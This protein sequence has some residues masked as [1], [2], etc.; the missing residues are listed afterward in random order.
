MDLTLPPLPRFRLYSRASDYARIILE[1]VAGTSDHGPG[2][3]ELESQIA[4]FTGASAATCVAKARVGVFLAMREILKGRSKTVILSPYTISDVVNMVI[5]AGGVPVFADLDKGTCN[6]SLECIRDLLCDDIGAVLITHLHGFACDVVGIGDLCRSHGVPVIEDAA[7]ALGTRVNNQPVGTFG[8]AGVFSFGAYKNLN[9]FFGGML[10]SNDE[11]LIE[12]V[13]RQSANFPEQ[14]LGYYLR[15]VTEC[16][17]TDIATHPLV[18][19]A[20]TFW[21]FRLA[22]LYDIG[23]FNAQVSYDLEPTLKRI[24]PETYLRRMRPLQARLGLAKLPQVDDD[25]EVRTQKA[26]MYFEGLKGAPGIELPPNRTDRSHTYTYFPIRV[27]DRRKYIR[28][29]MRAGRDV[30]IQH[31]KNCADLDCFAEFHRDCP[32]AR[33]TSREVVLLPTYPRYSV[34]EVERTI[35]ATRRYANTS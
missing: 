34:Q 31:L 24:L 19:R 14:E 35:S 17:A 10:V 21:I 1:S 20:F 27:R 13:S 28:H 22:T 4:Q 33:K 23:A 15:K 30:G 18:F 3:Q 16:L 25:A 5:C 29:M 11:T 2:C 32:V 12:S 9:T 7:Q 8:S 6:I 26:Q